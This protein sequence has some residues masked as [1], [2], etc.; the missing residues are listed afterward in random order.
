MEVSELFAQQPRRHPLERSYKAG[1]GHLWR[2]VD[3]QVY[4]IVLAVELN[5]LG[6]KVPADVG[7][8]QAHRLQVLLLEY[9]SPILGYEYQV[10]MEHK[11]AMPSVS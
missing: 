2:I 6:I 3:Q 5:K 7:H 9:T 10:N 8:D 11:D 4:V 1:Q